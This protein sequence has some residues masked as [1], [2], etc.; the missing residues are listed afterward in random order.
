MSH[1]RAHGENIL[2]TLWVGGLW[3]AGYVVAPVL[4]NVLDKSVAGEVAGRIFAVTSYI[5]LFCCTFLI[6]SLLSN[7]K[8]NYRVG[9]LLAMLGIIIVGQFVLAPMMTELKLA[10]IDKGS[11]NAIQFARLHGVSSVLYLSNSL[12]GLVLVVA[13]LRPAEPLQG[14]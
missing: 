2:L 4:F 14:S 8:K 12:M 13:G 7:A 3:F 11:D 6:L 1:Y 9:L 10:G 5:G